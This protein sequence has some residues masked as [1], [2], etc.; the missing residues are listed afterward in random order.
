MLCRLNLPYLLY[1]YD[2]ADEKIGKRRSRAKV[3]IGKII[4]IL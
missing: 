1:I 4:I 3:R 2:Y